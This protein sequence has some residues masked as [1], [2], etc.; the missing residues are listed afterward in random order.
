MKPK[1]SAT[2]SSAVQLHFLLSCMYAGSSMEFIGYQWTR[3]SVLCVNHCGVRRAVAHKKDIVFLNKA[4]HSGY[5]VLLM[6]VAGFCHRKIGL[7]ASQ[8]LLLRSAIMSTTTNSIQ[9]QL[10]RMTYFF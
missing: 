2:S 1:N 3:C 4:E 9:Q 10:F 8:K 5:L 6:S 7:Q